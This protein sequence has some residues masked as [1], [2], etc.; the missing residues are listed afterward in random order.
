MSWIPIGYRVVAALAAPCF[1]YLAIGGANPECVMTVANGPD[2]SR[3]D[4]IGSV[5]GPTQRVP[6]PPSFLGRWKQ[7]I[8]SVVPEGAHVEVRGYPCSGGT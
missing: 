8:V 3:A 1:V 4:A 7:W 5:P 2:M 6:C